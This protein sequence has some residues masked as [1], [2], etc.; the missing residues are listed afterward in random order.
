MVLRKQF[1]LFLLIGAFSL[2]LAHQLFPHHHHDSE[3]TVSHVH[4]PGAKHHHHDSP[5]SHKQ[6]KQVEWLDE[7]FSFFN[8][9]KTDAPMQSGCQLKTEFCKT[10]SIILPGFKA[11]QD[12]SLLE[13]NLTLPVYSSPEEQPTEHV[14]LFK[15]RRGPPAMA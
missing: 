12:F 6:E 5:E 10:I 15:S 11:T 9:S 4:E 13:Y 8:H 3:A 7:L 2:H 1:L 14:I